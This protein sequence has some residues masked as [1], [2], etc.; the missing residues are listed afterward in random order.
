MIVTIYLADGLIT[1]LVP[2]VISTITVNGVTTI[3]SQLVPRSGADVFFGRCM[4]AFVGGLVGT[5]FWG[6]FTWLLEE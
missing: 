3:V 1:S 2:Q 5:V 6:L 4:F